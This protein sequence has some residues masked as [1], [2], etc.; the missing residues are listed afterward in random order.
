MPA[1]RPGVGD[2]TARTRI[3]DAALRLFGARGVD[4]T[5][6]RDVA[7]EAGVSSGLVQH[8]YR[9]KE[10]LR[11]ACDT[12]VLAQLVRS[13]QLVLEEGLDN[14]VFLANSHPELLDLYRYLSRSMIDGSPAAAD[15]FT[16]MVGA[17]EQ[18]LAQH[19][20]GVV[21]DEHGYAT[22]LVAMEIGALALHPQLSGALGTDV[23]SPG[24]H[25]RLAR[26]KIEF[27]SKP[28]LDEELARQAVDTIDALLAELARNGPPEGGPD[29]AR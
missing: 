4:G 15:M 3:R 28:L 19:H 7:R 24:G 6:I 17:T 1:L 2:L 26:A 27:Y 22:V 16:E 12:Y 23:L 21:T 14:P 9:S 10:A 20:P 13:K 18:W 29:G 8:H 11:A 5:G 25:L